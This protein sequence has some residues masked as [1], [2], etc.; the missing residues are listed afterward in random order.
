MEPIFILEYRCLMP[1]TK[2]SLSESRNIR[3]YLLG[4]WKRLPSS[5]WKVDW[6]VKATDL[7]KSY[8]NQQE[9]K[10][11]QYGEDFKLSGVGARHGALSRFP[12]DLCQFLIKFYTNE[13][14]TVLDP[15][16]GHNSRM[17]SCYKVNRN[18]IGFDIC[19]QFMEW[20]RQVKNGLEEENSRCLTPL[21]SFILLYE[22]DSRN[23]LDYIEEESIDFCITS[24]PFYDIEY[25]GPEM[26]QLGR[27]KFY[28]DFIYSLGT[29]VEICFKALKEGSYI[30]WETNDF[31]RDKTFYTY[32]ADLINLFKRAGFLIHDIIIVDY[33]SSFLSSFLS[34]VEH[35]KIMPKQHSYIIIGRKITL[36]REPK[37]EETYKQLSAK[38]KEKKPNLPASL[39]QSGKHKNQ[40]RFDL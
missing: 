11:Q 6:S 9:E 31:R 24:P 8:G 32:H 35:N 30:A 10:S 33:G 22:V 20:N 26:E 12:Q 34:D 17:E 7:S 15:F 18:Y 4:Q 14:D 21:D 5:I 39:L 37:R 3:Q 13:G 38:A 23:I 16:A 2:E 1:K 28:N 19:H 29:I 36:K 27:A 40:I 25:Y